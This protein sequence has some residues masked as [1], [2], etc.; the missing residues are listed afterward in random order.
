MNVYQH[1]IIGSTIS[2]VIAHSLNHLHCHG[3]WVYAMIEL[4]QIDLQLKSV[5]QYHLCQ[6][7]RYLFTK[8]VV[9]LSQVSC[10]FSKT[11]TISIFFHKMCSNFFGSTTLIC[12]LIYCRIDCIVLRPTTRVVNM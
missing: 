11:A 7:S 12:Q 8:R 2:G 1:D 6:N 9:C 5:Q 3:A 10:N 4:Q